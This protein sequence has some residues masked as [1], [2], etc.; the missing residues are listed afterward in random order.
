MATTERQQNQDAF[1]K[2]RDH[3]QRT[4]AR[5]RFIAISGGRIIADAASFEELD[6][7]LHNMGR[8]TP[9]I[10]VVQAGIEYPENMTILLGQLP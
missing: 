3:I 2:L 7:A 8:H 4:Y 5:G 9:D 10:L 1:R 6:A